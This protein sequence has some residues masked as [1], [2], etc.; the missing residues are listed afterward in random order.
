MPIS[1]YRM[2]IDYKFVSRPPPSKFDVAILTPN[3]M[4]SGGGA[5][6]R[7]SGHERSLVMGSV[8]L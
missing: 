7:W 6:G 1:L 3:A 2:T 8:S 5:F 4:V